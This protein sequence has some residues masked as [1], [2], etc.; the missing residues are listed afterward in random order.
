V[1][2]A[3]ANQTEKQ[4]IH[5]VNQS[6][7]LFPN[8]SRCFFM[9]ITDNRHLAHHHIREEIAGC[10]CKGGC[11]R[12]DFKDKAAAKNMMKGARS[13]ARGRTAKPHQFRD[14]RPA[15]PQKKTREKMEYPR[16]SCIYFMHTMGDRC[17]NALCIFSRLGK[18]DLGA[19]ID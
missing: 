8:Q 19:F 3:E 13:A 14:V 1:L 2:H 6:A 15:V 17:L 11:A 4:S 9:H 7:A 10:R 5:A 12:G 16:S 18:S